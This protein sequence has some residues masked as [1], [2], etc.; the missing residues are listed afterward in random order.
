MSIRSYLPLVSDD[1]P[2]TIDEIDDETFQRAAE[3][4]EAHDDPVADYL[5]LTHAERSF[6]KQAQPGENSP[7]SE[8]LLSVSGYGRKRLSVH[9]GEYEHHVLDDDLD[10][11]RFLEKAGVAQSPDEPTRAVTPSSPQAT[12]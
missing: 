8:C 12:D 9:T 7:Y 6:I 2:P 11:W 3:I 1:S 4:L 5:D 10:P